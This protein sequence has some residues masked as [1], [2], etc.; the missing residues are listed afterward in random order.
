M[1][2]SAASLRVFEPVGGRRFP[3][4]DEIWRH[5]DLVYYLARREV[6]ARYK[7]SAV[8]VFWAILQPVLLATTFS[9]FLGLLAKVSSQP[10]I[11][12][13]VFAVSG[14]V[15]WMFVSGAIQAAS[16]STVG[17]ESLISKVYFPRIVIPLTYVFPAAVDFLVAFVVVIVS[18]VIY[19]VSFHLQ[20]LLMPLIMLLAFALILGA[21]LWLSA[22]NVKYRDIRQVVP[23]LTLLGLFISPIT[24]PFNLVPANLQPLYA[25]NPVAG[26]LAAYRWA[27]FGSSGASPLIIL[28][29]VVASVVLLITGAA[30]FQ[31]AEQTFADVI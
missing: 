21:S 12:Y 1:E 25:L 26:L 31:R 15:L 7:Q 29:P 24:Y 4:L 23:F 22:L 9:V 6:A 16:D 14:L 20:I 13:P 3:D 28:V 19:G 11:P 18:M 17:N 5:R 8:G 2:T 27:L 10:G 30:Y